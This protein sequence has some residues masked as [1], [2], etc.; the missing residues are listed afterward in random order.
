MDLAERR[1][2]QPG[3]AGG[4]TEVVV[5]A[6]G[7]GLQTALPFGE[8][9][10]GVRR[11]AGTGEVEQCRELRDHHALARQMVREGLAGRAAALEPRPGRGRCQPSCYGLEFLQL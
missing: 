7:I 9:P 10:V 3:I 1:P 5:A 8:V 2:D 11:P 4:A 6:T